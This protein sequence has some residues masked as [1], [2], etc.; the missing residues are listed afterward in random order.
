LRVTSPASG[1]ARLCVRR[2]AA[3]A[4]AALLLF[5]ARPATAAVGGE[6]TILSN[7][8]FRG[9][10]ISGGRPVA[11]LGL[12]YDDLAG[13]YAGLTITGV[14]ARD[15]EAQLLSVQEY[16]GFAHRL[17]PE[18]T[19]DLGVVN[20]DYARYWSGGRTARYTEIYAGLIGRRINGRVSFSP[21]YLQDGWKVAYGDVNVMLI[22]TEAWDVSVHG[23]LL[24][25]VAGG[26]PEGAGATHYDWQIGAGRRFGRFELRAA[27]AAGGPRP[28]YYRGRRRPHGA[29]T[30]SI[31]AAF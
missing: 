25:W 27:W 24:I 31:A 15:G 21:N 23:G 14:L 28:D 19:L 8:M 4:A 29:P 9:R 17:R 7:D 2:R 22:A 1:P 6:L 5:G 3:V 13:P 12:S 26:R 11:R 30:I 18:L 16:A 20:T 10:S